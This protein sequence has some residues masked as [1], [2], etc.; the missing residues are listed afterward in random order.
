MLYCFIYFSLLTLFILFG[1]PLAA[2]TK[3]NAVQK[4]FEILENEISIPSTAS[5]K[6]KDGNNILL[7][8]FHGHVIVLNFFKPNCRPCLLELPSLD[9]LAQTFKGTSVIILTIAEGEQNSEIIEKVFYERRLKN[10]TI[11]LDENEQLLRIL[12]GEKVPRTLLI[13][14]KGEIIGALQGQADFSSSV[15]INQIKEAL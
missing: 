12:G 7:S 9:R 2:Q 6:D 11:A 13:N 15:L 14:A 8:S 1:K 10:L 4:S 5:F 3:I